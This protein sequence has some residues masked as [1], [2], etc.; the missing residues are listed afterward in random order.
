MSKFVKSSVLTISIIVVAV[1]VAGCSSRFVPQ[2]EE[3][4]YPPSSGSSSNGP[5]NGLIQSNTEGS[6]T[7]DVEWIKAEND[8]LV[9]NVAMNT[10]S[11]ELDEYDLRELVVLRD[12]R[13]NES[14]PVS[15]DSA[16]GGHHRQGTLTFPI[17]DSVSQGKARYVEIMI[18]DVAGIEERVLKWEL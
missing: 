16:P 11:V 14:H 5:T 4:A 15:W 8:S 13:G 12:D 1:I 3:G 7:I 9:F 6:V 2:Q 10:H 18:R 17:P